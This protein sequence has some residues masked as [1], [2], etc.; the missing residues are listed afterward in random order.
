MSLP[1]SAGST[2]IGRDY[3][4]IIRMLHNI[5]HLL[6]KELAKA[7][8][9][10]AEA[11]ANPFSACRAGA[12]EAGPHGNVSFFRVASIGLVATRGKTGK[13]RGLEAEFEHV[14]S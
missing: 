7:L 10:P 4:Y 1:A 11:R 12:T 2:D 9:L 14:V 6:N 5:V 13:G 3:R 8:R